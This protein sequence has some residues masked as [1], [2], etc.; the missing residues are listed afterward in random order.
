M[1]KY[2]VSIVFVC[3]GN[4]CRSPLAEGVF[5]HLVRHRGLEARF[6]IDSAGTTAYHEGD[7]PDARSVAVART[8]GVV[9]TGRSRPL[10]RIDLNR[11]DYVIVMDSEN[12]AAVERL[13]GAARPRAVVKRLL[14]FDPDSSADL[15]VP[16]PY[17]SD[18]NGF[19]YVHDLIE[20]ACTH[21]LDWIVQERGW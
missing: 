16:D 17:F 11:F 19:E 8:R 15:D 12:L 18:S 6:V 9:V 21:L 3:L 5:R 4:I 7:P 13:R 1:G 2:E 20:R 10:R 14:E